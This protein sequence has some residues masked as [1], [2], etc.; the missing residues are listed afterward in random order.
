V[1]L[2]DRAI[3]AVNARAAALG[4][5]P[6]KAP[7]QVEGQD[8]ALLFSGVPVTLGELVPWFEQRGTRVLLQLLRGD[9]PDAALNGVFAEWLLIGYYLARAEAEEGV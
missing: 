1:T 5:M 3:E 6:G 4:A 7:V 2:L 8:T 9:P